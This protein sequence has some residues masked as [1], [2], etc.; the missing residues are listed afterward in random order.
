MPVK[1]ATVLPS[2][3]TS[4]PDVPLEPAINPEALAIAERLLSEFGVPRRVRFTPSQL[5]Q[6]VGGSTR[7]WQRECEIGNIGAV[8]SVGGWIVSWHRLVAYVARRQNIV[9]MN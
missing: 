1:G 3:D 8:H 7:A 9:E 5:A 4:T 6:D 2:D